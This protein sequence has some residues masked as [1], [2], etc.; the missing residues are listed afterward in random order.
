MAN[1]RV[2][3]FSHK[4]WTN[5]GLGGFWLILCKFWTW[6]WWQYRGLKDFFEVLVFIW[7]VAT[8][9]MGED[10]NHPLRLREYGAEWSGT[11]Q[12]PSWTG[13]RW[14]TVYSQESLTSSCTEWESR[15]CSRTHTIKLDYTHRQRT[16]LRETVSKFHYDQRYGG[17][18]YR[19]WSTVVVASSCFCRR[20]WWWQE[21][22]TKLETGLVERIKLANIKLTLNLSPDLDPTEHTCTEIYWYS[23]PSLDGRKPKRK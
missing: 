19:L 15:S 13:C 18:L 23:W 14:N 21:L 11:A 8:W 4:R 2:A 5:W 7:Y 6:P 1:L 20:N 16:I 17:T 3:E 9:T 22:W 10:L 12:E